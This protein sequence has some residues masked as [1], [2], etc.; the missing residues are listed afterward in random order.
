MPDFL[1]NTGLWYALFAVVLVV[2]AIFVIRSYMK[3]LARGC[4][5]SGGDGTEQKVK[6]RDRDKSHYPYIAKL[7]IDGMVCGS[8]AR[9]IENALNKIDGVWA[10]VDVS[11]K[12]DTVRMKHP[13]SDQLLRDTVNYIG[14]YTVMRILWEENRIAQPVVH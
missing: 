6:V 9:R 8:C 11:A 2:F 14:G 1:Q 4:C 3:K 13:L 7:V 10:R 5:G 12:Q